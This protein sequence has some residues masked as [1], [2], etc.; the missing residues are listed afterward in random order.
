[1]PSG[2]L[3]PKVMASLCRWL[4]IQEK[5]ALVREEIAKEAGGHDDHAH[6]QAFFQAGRAQAFRDVFSRLTKYDPALRGPFSSEG[7]A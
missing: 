2:V 6:G 4:I 1:M 5:V 3:S 7:A